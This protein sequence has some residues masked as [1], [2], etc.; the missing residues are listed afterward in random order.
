[1]RP[2]KF[3]Y[4]LCLSFLAIQTCASQPTLR[5]QNGYVQGVLQGHV[6]SFKG[7][8]FAAPPIGQL[9]W[10]PPQDPVNW[11]GIRDASGFSER[12]P[13]MSRDA[14]GP[15]VF[16]GNEDCLYLNV[17][18][19][20]GAT[21]LPIIVFI[22][23]GSN[24]SGSASLELNAVPVYDGASL[25]QNGNVVVV[26]ANYRLGNLG[27]LVH[28]KLTE[29]SGY[30]GSGNY[31]YMDQ[32]Q[33]LKWVQRNIAAFGGDPGNV[34]LFGQS[35][36][37][38]GVWVLMTSPLSA[39][40]FHR[41]IVHSGVREGARKL[42]DAHQV[43]TKVSQNLHCSSA[44]DELACLRGKPASE[45]VKA[46]PFVRGKGFF[47]AV[48][49]NK[50]L[51][52]PPIDTMLEGKHHHVPILQGNVKEEMSILGLEDSRHITNEKEYK[53]AV[54]DAVKVGPDGVSIP[55]VTATEL[56]GLY[57]VDDYSSPRHAYNAIRTDRDYICSSRKVLRALSAKQNEFVGRFFYTHRFSDGAERSFGASHGF[58]LLF[59]FDSLKAPMPPPLVPTAGERDL[60]KF[61][62]RTWSDFARTGM[63]SPAWKR[64]DRARDNYV[65]LDAPIPR[66]EGEHLRR[67]QCDFWDA[68]PG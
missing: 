17:F 26:T 48:L 46:L 23:G 58:E 62:Q 9:R 59:I 50:V 5:T 19:P 27:F 61:F 6:E 64:Y 42:E 18:K 15:P 12:C 29:A 11:P 40:L 54:E 60:V 10:M 57:P 1:M 55:G 39:G 16:V 66:E 4:A 32:I 47:S 56:L 36:G 34:T 52:L 63:P 14:P 45:V 49:D 25:A 67:K 33:V 38:K 31:A 8:P 53:D 2:P 3:V 68:H 21:G 37:A 43:G 44:P 20:S 22:H 65:A 28:K 7:L 13:Q 51:M 41:A 24:V 30:Q 35:A